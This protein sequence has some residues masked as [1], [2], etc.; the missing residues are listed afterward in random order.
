MCIITKKL[1]DLAGQSSLY[2]VF[3][4]A[5]NRKGARISELDSDLKFYKELGIIPAYVTEYVCHTTDDSS[6]DDI[7]PSILTKGA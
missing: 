2:D 1:E 5:L 4:K 7:Y 3:L 6:A